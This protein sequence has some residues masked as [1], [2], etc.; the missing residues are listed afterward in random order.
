MTDST[1][2]YRFGCAVS[3]FIAF[4]TVGKCSVSS[5]GFKSKRGSEFL[6]FH[7]T[8]IFL[9]FSDFLDYCIC[10]RIYNL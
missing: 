6:H 7:V 10:L 4:L 1:V 8:E 3:Y 5:L 9:S 2:T